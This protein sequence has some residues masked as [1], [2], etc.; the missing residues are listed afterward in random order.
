M[1]PT[2]PAPG[3]LELVRA[4]VNTHNVERRTDTLTSPWEREVREAIRLALVANHDRTPVPP[5]V[6]RVLDE[7]A[8]RVGLSVR[9]TADGSFALRPARR[10][11]VGDVLV[12]MTEAMTDGTWSRLKV[13]WDDEC[14]WAF[15]D[16]SRA[17]TAKWC[18]MEVC[19][20]R[21]KQKA[22]RDRGRS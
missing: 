12:A 11:R 13:C 10:S 7:A 14:L 22:W 17:R 6:V 20:N 3:Q 19:G 4:F 16:N 8:E 15:Y 18:S 1:S 9:F 2:A 5:A 21:M